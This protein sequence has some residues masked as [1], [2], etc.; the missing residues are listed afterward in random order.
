MD[1]RR[2]LDRIDN[3]MIGILSK[4]GRISVTD[5]AERVGL[6]KSPCQVRLKRLIDEGFIRGFSA[7]LDHQRSQIVQSR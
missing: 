5:L 3:R 7:V 1:N 2:E 6:S 4:E